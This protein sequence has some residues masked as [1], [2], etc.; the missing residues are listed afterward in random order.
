[1]YFNG[2][3]Q[4]TSLDS[5]LPNNNEPRQEENKKSNSKIKIII[6][7]AIIIAILVIIFFLIS[8]QVSIKLYGNTDII[9]YQNSEYVDPGYE[10]INKFGKKVN[11]EA[12]IEGKVDSTYPG[13]YI[14][15]YS[16][17]NSTKERKVTV[18]ANSNQITF[19]FLTGGDVIRLN[20]GEKY[21][22]PG[23][24]V[25]DS[26]TSGLDKNVVVTGSVNEQVPGTYK[27]VYSVT[28][29][30]GVTISKERTV[31]INE[32]YMTSI[33]LDKT[34]VTLTEGGS[35][36]IKANVM[37]EN[38]TDKTLTWTSSN[39]KVASVTDAGKITGVSAGTASI[40]VKGKTGIIAT[41]NVKVNKKATPK[42]SAKSSSKSSAKSSSKATTTT[43]AYIDQSHKL[44]GSTVKDT[45]ESST[46]KYWI[47]TASLDYKTYGMTTVNMFHVWVKDPYKQFKVALGGYDHFER[48]F[49]GDLLKQEI[50]KQGYQNK[51]LVATNGSFFVNGGG[52][53]WNNT[54]RTSYIIHN[55]KVIRDDTEKDLS[56]EQAFYNVAGITSYGSLKL[57]NI[58]SDKSL[59]TNIKN[60]G[61]KYTVA[62]TPGILVQN[63]KAATHGDPV[64]ASRIGLCQVD[65]NNFIMIFAYNPLMQKFANFLANTMHCQTA[66]NIDGGG[67]CAMFYKKESGSLTKL[68]QTDRTV[69]DAIY[70]VEQ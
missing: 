19:L 24:T 5:E 23:Y 1:M 32:I 54:P 42:S 49:V 18:L 59:R 30:S 14:I 43:K 56:K 37:P 29:S 7:A 17:G 39:T 45:Y 26:N 51:G 58:R 11:K 31:I 20:V 6:I 25:L 15:K 46:L 57:Y 64:A 68:R 16:I 53:M 33:K 66:V 27:I 65:Q 62:A 13:E 22:E 52:S 36:T 4:N 34:S 63:G 9:I 61:I 3:V 70:F 44:S 12:T 47:E 69:P 55:G 67:S 2:D 40:T 8:N 10:V 35:T 41:C 50:D 38:T 28:N 60:D 48:K 21:I